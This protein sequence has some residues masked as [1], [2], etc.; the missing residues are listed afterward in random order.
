MKEE[1]EEKMEEGRKGG[2]ERKKRKGRQTKL[3]VK[4]F[5]CFFVLF[6]FFYILESSMKR[7]ANIQTDCFVYSKRLL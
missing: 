4:R 6:L 7:N 5:V 2:M 1:R 3:L